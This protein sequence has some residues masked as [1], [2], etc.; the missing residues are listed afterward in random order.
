M[1]IQELGIIGCD[2]FEK[3]L[4]EFLESG[5][6]EAAGIEVVIDRYLAET[7]A[8][9]ARKSA[10]NFLRGAIGTIELMR[11]SW[12]TRPRS[13]PQ[14]LVFSIRSLQRSSTPFLQSCL[15]GRQSATRFR[16]LDRGV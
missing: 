7:E 5:L 8:M 16:W 15:E 13:F 4:V 11:R 1:L 14:A 10:Q 6:F 3:H 9:K 12:W 2:D